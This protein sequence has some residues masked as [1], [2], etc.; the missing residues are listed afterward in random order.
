M[1][2]TKN[3][4]QPFR[5]EKKKRTSGKKTRGQSSAP[6]RGKL[7]QKGLT[8]PERRRFWGVGGPRSD[9]GAG[10]GGRGVVNGCGLQEGESTSRGKKNDGEERP[11][12]HG[13]GKKGKFCVFGPR[14]R[15]VSAENLS[16]IFKREG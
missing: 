16:N 15:S 9:A 14:A 4:P 1:M 12:V 10:P 11:L 6:P 2:F 5:T 7:R 3:G 13:G 8:M